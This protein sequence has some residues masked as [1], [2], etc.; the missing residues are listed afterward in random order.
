MASRFLVGACPL[1]PIHHV[2]PYALMSTGTKRG[3]GQVFDG[4]VR[5]PFS[6]YASTARSLPTSECGV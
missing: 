5:S 2:F 1:P 3:I 6:R 4:R